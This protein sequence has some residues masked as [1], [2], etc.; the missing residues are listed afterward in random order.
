MPS[1]VPRLN[2][3]YQKREMVSK[4]EAQ[5]VRLLKTSPE[6]ATVNRAAEKVRQAHLNL[7]KAERELIEP[8]QAKGDGVVGHLSNLRVQTSRWE[9]LSIPEIVARYC[10]TRNL[11]L[12]SDGRVG[13]F[14]PS[15]VRR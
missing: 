14:A 11:P 3:P 9:Q 13:R 8:D 2:E 1:Y 4:R 12:Q 15:R 7:L 5:L 10:P 6:S